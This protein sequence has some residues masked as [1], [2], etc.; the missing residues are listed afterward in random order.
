MKHLF[1]SF[2]WLFVAIKYQFHKSNPIAK[3][4]AEKHRTRGRKN[5]GKSSVCS[6][7]LS[8][9]LFFSSFLCGLGSESKWG[10]KGE[11]IF[12]TVRGGWKTDPRGK[13]TPSLE[14][15]R[16]KWGELRKNKNKLDEFD[17][18]QLAASSLTRLTGVG[19]KVMTC[20]FVGKL[21][22]QTLRRKQNY[23][24]GY[25]NWKITRQLFVG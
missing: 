8:F 3:V 24:N 17:D 11:N 4:S 14:R 5:W 19:G 21:I 15:W 10:K 13:D 16:A 20:R 25:R 12:L 23:S 1:R 22:K 2:G 9:I 6:K 18:C 7:M